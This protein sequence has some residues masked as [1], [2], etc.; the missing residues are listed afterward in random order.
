MYMHS[1]M[2]VCMHTTIMQCKINA[3]FESSYRDG[4]DFNADVS[5]SLIFCLLPT[6]I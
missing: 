5:K 3:H 2:Y 6:K 4:G 1:Y